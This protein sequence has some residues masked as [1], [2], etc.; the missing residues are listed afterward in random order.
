MREK[1]QMSSM[2]ELTFFLR[3]QGKQKNDGTFINQDKYVAEILKKFGF[4]E[5]KTASTPMK[6]Q[7]PLLKDEDGEEVDV[8]MY[9]SM[10]GSLM[11]LTSSRPNIMFAVCAY[12][13]YQVNLNISH[14]HAIKKIRTAFD[15]ESKSD[16]HTYQNLFEFSILRMT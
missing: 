4:T 10:I 6:T 13:R 12:A 3:L 2:G 5:V 1:F 16:I 15:L 11:Y 14:L 8:H 7:K 9:S